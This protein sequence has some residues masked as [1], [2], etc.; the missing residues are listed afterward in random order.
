MKKTKT[1]SKI[2]GRVTVLI[3]IS[4]MISVI[5]AGCSGGGGGSGKDDPEPST[6]TFTLSGET[7]T[8]HAGG[9]AVMKLN[10]A[11]NPGVAY[12][13]VTVETNPDSGIELQKAENGVILSDLDMGKNLVWSADSNSKANGVLATLTFNVPVGTPKGDYPVTIVLRECY[14]D[15]TESIKPEPDIINGK[16]VVN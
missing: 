1:K 3:L 4:M 11:N 2:I 12:I 15:Q 8:A 6:K 7:V 16:I 13:R 5:A 9:Q 14:N 10:L